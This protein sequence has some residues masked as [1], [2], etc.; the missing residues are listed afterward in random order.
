MRL[1]GSGMREGVFVPWIV[2]NQ[3]LIIFFIFQFF[4][5]SIFFYIVTFHHFEFFFC[6]KR[7]GEGR[8]GVRKTRATYKEEGGDEDCWDADDM[9][10]YIDLCIW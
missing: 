8:E 4:N 6:K 7:K 3:F 2:R 1:A 10:S 5:F 9:D